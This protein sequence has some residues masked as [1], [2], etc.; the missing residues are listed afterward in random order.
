MTNEERE[1]EFNK[2]RVGLL[3][4]TG[5]DAAAMI[6]ENTKLRIERDK[7]IEDLRVTMIRF[8]STGNLVSGIE[9]ENDELRLARDKAETAFGQM[10]AVVAALN[11]LPSFDHGQQITFEG[12]RYILVDPETV[13]NIEAALK[14]MK[15]DAK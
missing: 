11:E 10:R 1:I 13:E 14:S 15:E 9:A 8:I 5:M 12:C 6:E 3:T 4:T 2:W 7:A